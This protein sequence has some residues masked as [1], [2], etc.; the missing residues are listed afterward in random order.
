MQCDRFR[1]H[2]PRPR[3]RPKPERTWSDTHRGSRKTLDR[4]SRVQSP[5]RSP[6][7]S[8]ARLPLTRCPGRN[9]SRLRAFSP[10]Q[11]HP[12][13]A[14]GEKRRNLAA[15]KSRSEKSRSAPASPRRQPGRIAPHASPD[16][17]ICDWPERIS[18]E[19]HDE[20]RT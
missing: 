15:Y 5:G 18:T 16:S 20:E 3:R 7:Q 14:A 11:R 9:R 13:Q 10:L 6:G 8:Q 19:A 17:T 2:R 4:G 1:R 12:L